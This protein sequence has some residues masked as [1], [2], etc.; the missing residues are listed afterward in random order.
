[1]HNP[2]SDREPNL[3][4]A[5]QIVAERLTHMFNGFQLTQLFNSGND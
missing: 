3:A 4:T 5:V 2:G 1:M